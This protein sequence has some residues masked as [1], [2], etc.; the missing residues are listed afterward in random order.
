MS[1]F[2]KSNVLL[3]QEDIK[4]LIEAD[5]QFYNIAQKPKSTTIKSKEYKHLKRLIWRNYKRG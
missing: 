3:T 2:H 1:I 5:R 4:R